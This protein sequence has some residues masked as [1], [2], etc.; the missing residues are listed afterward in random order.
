MAN[1]FLQPERFLQVLYRFGKEGDDG[2]DLLYTDAHDVITVHNVHIQGDYA[3]VSW[4]TDGVYVFGIS[5]ISMPLKSV[6]DTY[7]QDVPMLGSGPDGQA[8]P[9]ISRTC[10][11][12]PYG[13]HVVVGDTMGDCF[14]LTFFRYQY[15]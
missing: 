12:C 5:D 4:Y 15:R 13:S 9:P 3:F 7:E 10:R 6:T 8:P 14:C 2:F 1:M 11:C